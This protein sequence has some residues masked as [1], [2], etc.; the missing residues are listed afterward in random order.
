[1]DRMVREAEA[2]AEEDRRKR[3]SAETRNQAEQLVYQTEQ[4]LKDNPDKIPEDV[5]AEVRGALGEVKE[6]L[7]GEDVAAIRTATERA[8]AAAQK[9]GAAIYAQAQGAQ[10]GAAGTGAGGDG[11]TAGPSAGPAGASDTGGSAQA[12]EDVVDAE[13]VDDEDEKKGGTG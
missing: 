12:D 11:G 3:E 9:A 1:I 5:A 2:H 13:I 4:L 10:A 7:K 6:T 8:Q